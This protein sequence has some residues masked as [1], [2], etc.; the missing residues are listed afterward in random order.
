MAHTHTMNNNTNNNNNM[1]YNNN[2]TNNNNN[3]NEYQ[4][5]IDSISDIE[6]ETSVYV[7]DGAFIEQLL[8][9]HKGLRGVG[10]LSLNDQNRQ[11]RKTSAQKSTHPSN[12]NNNNNSNNSTNSI[13][14]K[15]S[16]G[17]FKDKVFSTIKKGLEQVNQAA[18]GGGGGNNTT[19]TNS[20]SSTSSSSSTGKSVVDQSSSTPTSSLNSSSNSSSSSLNETTTTTTHTSIN[21]QLSINDTYQL[22]VVFDFHLFATGDESIEIHFAMYSLNE[23][24]FI[25]ESIVIS[26]DSG[27]NRISLFRDI[28]GSNLLK[29]DLY[30]VGR[31]FRKYELGH[32]NS[33]NTFA[34]SKNL[35]IQS[36]SNSISPNKDDLD[37]D[38]L[39]RPLAVCAIPF[40]S[41]SI[42]E[43][44][45]GHSVTKYCE[46]YE[47]SHEKVGH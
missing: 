17:S 20:S 13:S 23:A 11:K 15:K 39:R 16:K 44:A 19:T 38:T 6:N 32:Q 30:L 25:S 34:S 5:M 21:N 46:F 27:K 35:S 24:R 33:L 45:N 3:T 42:K 28:T 26:S 1:N 18:T 14:D 37:I 4:S 40:D 36:S 2:T 41:E 31:A 22:M 9:Q 29:D 47:K 12:N 7:S 10:G 43:L 8:S